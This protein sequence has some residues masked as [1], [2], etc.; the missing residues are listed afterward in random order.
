MHIG[1]YGILRK[2]NHSIVKIQQC[3][4]LIVNGR[5]ISF[6]NHNYLKSSVKLPSSTFI[7][8]SNYSIHKRNFQVF[9]RCTA[10]YGILSIL[11]IWPP[12]HLRCAEFLVWERELKEHTNERV[13]DL[14]LCLKVVGSSS[15]KLLQGM[16]LLPTKV[17]VFF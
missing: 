3:R 2:Q 8:K 4:R 9:P 5:T 13:G 14:S 11:S 16:I 7:K 1:N 10:L 17:V 15:R 6:I 12:L